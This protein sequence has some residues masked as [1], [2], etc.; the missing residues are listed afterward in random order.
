M[1]TARKQDLRW[2]II[3]SFFTLSIINVWFGLLGIL[4]MTAPLY[5]AIRGRGRH[6][7]RYHCPRGSFMN[8]IIRRISLGYSMPRFMAT[9]T[10]RHILLGTMVI[11]LSLGLWHSG[12]DAKKIA[13]ILFRFMGISFIFG[14]LLGII[15]KSKSWCAV[16]PMGHA[17]VLITDI[18][19]KKAA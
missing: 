7:C 14:S 11:M 8:N 5:H 2:I 3:V 16:C 17:A 10:F 18:R 19:K 9:K 12:G 1:N 6:H 4:C 13:F 15:F